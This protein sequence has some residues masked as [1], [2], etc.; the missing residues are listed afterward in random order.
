MG[1]R[2]TYYVGVGRIHSCAICVAHDTKMS[3]AKSPN[4]EKIMLSLTTSAA[5]NMDIV[6]EECVIGGRLAEGGVTSSNSMRLES[7]TITL[8]FLL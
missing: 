3:I 6:Y 4:F 5:S 2:H 8:H 1:H 7:M